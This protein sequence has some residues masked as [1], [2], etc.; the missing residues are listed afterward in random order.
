MITT[1]QLAYCVITLA[2]F[3]GI[4]F[5]T[6]CILIN[7]AY[8]KLASA[9]LRLDIHD[10]YL[11][12]FVKYFKFLQETDFEKKIRFYLELK[13]LRKAGG[14]IAIF[15]SFEKDSFIHHLDQHIVDYL[16]LKTDGRDIN[17]TIEILHAELESV[18]SILENRPAL[19]E[20]M[21]DRTDFGFLRTLQ[22]A[23]GE[24]SE[25]KARNII[26]AASRKFE[27]FANKYLKNHHAIGNNF[28]FLIDELEI[29]ND[30][31]VR[32]IIHQWI[33]RGGNPDART[34]R[35][36]DRDLG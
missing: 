12:F 23:Y 27:P 8:K 15:F 14:N 29:R 26:F 2:S 10:D 9:K 30:K 25:E 16:I 5:I 32:E 28:S 24:E 31:T 33:G 18:W 7:R 1:Q 34:S 22:K 20:K 19:I 21:A 17:K 3:T 11:K 6:F 13:E 4:G 36:L 35:K